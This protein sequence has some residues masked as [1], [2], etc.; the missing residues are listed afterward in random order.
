MFRGTYTAIVTPFRDGEIDVPALEALVE[1]Q[2]ADGVTGVIAVGTTGESPTLSAAEREQVIRVTVE[3]GKGRCQVLAGTGSNST[4]ATITATRAAEKM[5]VDGML[6]VAPYYNKP[7]QEGLFRHFQ[8]IAQATSVPIMLYNIPGR[9]AVDIGPDTVERLAM[10]CANIVSIKEAGG[11]VD[12]VSELRARLPEAFTILSGD[13]ALTLPFLS[14][15]AVGVVSVASNLFPAEVVALVQAFRTGD[16]K[17]AREMHIKMLPIFK[18]LFIEPNPVPVKTA[19]SWRGAMSAECRLPLCEMS[20]ANQAR[21]R[22][23]L[24]VLEESR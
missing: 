16:T 10:D 22:K 2:I 5:G 20:A 6:V 11:S 15:G 13:D 24:D 23:A 17:S 18:D 7:N 12:R 21:L 1:G 9:C 8:A 19:L 3:V 4:S 14:V